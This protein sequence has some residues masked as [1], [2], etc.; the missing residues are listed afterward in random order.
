M[1]HRCSLESKSKRAKST[2]SSTP[3]VNPALVT[4]AQESQP[5]LDVGLQDF[6]ARMQADVKSMFANFIAQFRRDSQDSHV[7]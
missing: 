1:K 6:Q 7:S 2:D 4:A 3:S 5:R